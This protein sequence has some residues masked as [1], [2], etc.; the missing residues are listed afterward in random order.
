[1]EIKKEQEEQIV[2]CGAFEYD[3]HKL[4]SLLGF[5]QKEVEA[6][7]KDKTSKLFQLLKKGK[8]TAD[9]VIDLKLFEMAKSGDIKALEKIDARKNIRRNSQK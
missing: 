1:M 8:D 3:S 7:M 9:Y 5:D 2:N 4:A 6:S